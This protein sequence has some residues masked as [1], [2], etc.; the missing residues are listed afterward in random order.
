[1]DKIKILIVDDEKLIR[2]GLKLMLST[3]S[4][5]EI[6]GTVANGNE[7]LEFCINHTVDLILMDIRMPIC[8]GVRGT[9][10]IKEQFEKVKILILTTF[11][12]TEYIQ[13]AFK[14]GA[15]G[16]LLKDSDCEVIYEGIKSA[17]NG[18]MIINHEIA[19]KIIPKEITNTSIDERLD[20]LS[21]K[22]IDIIKLV[23][24]G[25]TNKE[26]SLNLYLSEGTVKNN[27]TAILSKL[28]LRDRTQI[29]I[30]AFKNKIVT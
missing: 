20:S 18:N 4:E 12:D 28:N 2:N 29:A 19:Q 9:K 27:I 24:T 30:F 16:Y 23:A 17:M 22:D 14:Y 5:L 1:M 15:F 10:I 25:L 6:V 3:F 8:D 26:I 13:D 11:K 7:A 21:K